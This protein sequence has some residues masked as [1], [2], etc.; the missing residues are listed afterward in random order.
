VLLNGSASSDPDGDSLSY[1]WAQVSGASVALQNAGSANPSF[2]AAQ[3]SAQEILVFE[4]TVSDGE[5]SDV[6]SVSITLLPP[7]SN[8]APEVSVPASVSV[9]EGASVNITANATDADGDPLT[10]NWSAPGFNMANGNS[11]TVT[12]TAPQVGEDTTF[13]VT[14]TVSDGT[15]DVSAQ[16]AVN[17]TDIPPGGG[18][19]ITD[20]NAGS[21][22]A[23]ASGSTYLGGDRA[24]HS[25]LVW[26][27]KYWT[28]TEPG[29]A[30]ADW[31]LISAVEVPWNASTA[32]SGNH[33]VNHN[34][35]RYRAQWWTQGDE[36]GVASV[37]QDIGPASCN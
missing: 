10:Y 13:T 18:C 14:V 3:V 25:D 8:T 34:D 16:V 15:D 36:P 17:V 11:A 2:N 27:A 1:S 28:Q 37:W 31:K 24:S 21:Y 33:E 5:L 23:W 20:P 12:L 32:Y 29:F 19:E 35:R 7:A 4:L 22:P 30:A 9:V 6:D 26:E